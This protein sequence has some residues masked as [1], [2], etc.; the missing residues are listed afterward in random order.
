MPQMYL[1]VSTTF[2]HRWVGLTFM[3]IACVP[4]MLLG[5]EPS[6]RATKRLASIA[7]R[8]AGPKVTVS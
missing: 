1:T 5:L 7:Y 4:F 2:R 8:L 3:A 6:E